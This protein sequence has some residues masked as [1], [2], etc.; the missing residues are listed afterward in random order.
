MHIEHS[1]EDPRKCQ[2]IVNL[3]RIIAPPG[4]NNSSPRRFCCFRIYLRHRVCT[5]EHNRIFRHGLR[6]FF[7]QDIRRTD[8]DKYICLLYDIFQFSSFS[9][10]IGNLCDFFFYRI[11]VFCT[12]FVD[13]TCPV[14]ENNIAHS[15][16]EQKLC[17]GNG[18]SPCPIYCHP[19]IFCPFLY[20]F[21]CID[22]SC[23]RYHG[24]PMLV[25]V[26]DRDIAA[27]LQF[28]LN[29]KASRCRNILQI[30][31]SKTAGYQSYGIYN[32]IHIFAADTEWK[33]IHTA[34]RF[35]QYT[36]A[37]HN[38]HSGLRTD[39][40]QSQHCRSVCY[41]QAEIP[42]SGKLIRFTDIFLYLQAGCCHPRCVRK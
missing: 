24:C 5:R 9:G 30:N 3:V 16:A 6:H 27:L 7:C 33:C 26:K 21:Q 32:L 28:F 2:H 15:I 8:T 25:I 10:T 29:F 34:K 31:S 39:I 22:E 37:L 20:Q 4:C 11:H 17:D 12:A 13:C 36:F 23:Q 19:D 42:S 38:R 14:A 35:E 40:S 18:S 1:A 41:H